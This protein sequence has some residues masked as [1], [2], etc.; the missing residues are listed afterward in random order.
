MDAGWEMCGG[1]G[2]D[3]LVRVWNVGGGGA[4]RDGSGAEMT[5]R[6]HGDRVTCVKSHYTLFLLL[7]HANSDIV[8]TVE[9]QKL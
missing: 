9:E 4:G 1:G 2:D 8:F 3:G 6:G 5:L 7:L